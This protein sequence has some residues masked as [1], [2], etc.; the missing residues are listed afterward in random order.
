MLVIGKNLKEL[1]LIEREVGED[2]Y[3]SSQDEMTKLVGQELFGLKLS[4]QQ[5][6][7]ALMGLVVV[8]VVAVLVMFFQY[9]QSQNDEED[10][11]TRA[12]T[13]IK[14]EAS[15]DKPPANFFLAIHH[16]QPL[17]VPLG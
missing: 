6:I 1:Q 14:L 10:K 5:A 9:Q 8:A 4:P 3:S 12:K 13:R 15:I 16:T 11:K 2:S 17:Q 7:I